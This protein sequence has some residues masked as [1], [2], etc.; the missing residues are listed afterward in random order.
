MKTFLNLAVLFF[1][2][3]ALA[4]F[5]Y[6]TCEGVMRM[7]EGLNTSNPTS[8]AKAVN[9]SLMAD[10]TQNSITFAGKNEDDQSFDSQ[11]GEISEDG[12]SIVFN[13][14]GGAKAV[15]EVIEINQ[16]GNNA[17]NDVTLSYYDNDGQIIVRST[18]LLDCNYEPEYAEAFE[19]IFNKNFGQQP[20]QD[21]TAGVNQNEIEAVIAG[22]EAASTEATSNVTRE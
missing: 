13:L 2:M 20:T 8:T 4:D 7:Q 9:L 10:G 15:M 22:A 18:G 12:N 14:E 1:T 16:Q 5:Q 21:C 6:R 19:N 11:I 17:V 3:N